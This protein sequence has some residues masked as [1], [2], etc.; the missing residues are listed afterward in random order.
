MPS[1][2]S[3]ALTK[4]VQAALTKKTFVERFQAMGQERRVEQ[5]SRV[6]HMRDL[7]EEDR[8]RIREAARESPRSPGE[9]AGEKVREIRIERRRAQQEN[10]D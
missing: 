3:S 2:C 8:Q 1:A 10:N 7:S 5:G 9:L 4:Q 6:I